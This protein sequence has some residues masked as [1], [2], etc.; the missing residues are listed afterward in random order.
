MHQSVHSLNNHSMDSCSHDN[1][2]SNHKTYEDSSLDFVNIN[3]MITENEIK[4]APELLIEEIEGD[5][6]K[7][8]KLVINA[9][10]MVNGARKAKDGI[11]YFGTKYKNVSLITSN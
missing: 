8:N 7:N 10:G 9:A 5:I 11:V 3:R 2:K 6:L 4:S 1:H